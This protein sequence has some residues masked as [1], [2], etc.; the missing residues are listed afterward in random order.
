MVNRWVGHYNIRLLVYIITNIAEFT[1]CLAGHQ[2]RLKLFMIKNVHKKVAIIQGGGR[3]F[4]IGE[5]V[6][7]AVR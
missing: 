4:S 3:L 2:G 7:P 6:V 1:H 5:G